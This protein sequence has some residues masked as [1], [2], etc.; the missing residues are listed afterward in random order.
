MKSLIRLPEVERRTAKSVSEIYKGMR[1]GTFP[2]AVKIGR[3]SVAWV[4][5]EIDRYVQTRITA[6]DSS[7]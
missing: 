1:E 3:R 7:R 2:R 5:E 4:E 6:R